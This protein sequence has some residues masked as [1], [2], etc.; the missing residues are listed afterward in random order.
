MDT[1]SILVY[2]DA[3]IAKLQTVRASIATISFIDTEIPV[4]R[5]PGR[6]RKGALVVA[7]PKKRQMSA[8]GRAR[9]A[10]AQKTR[11]AAKKAVAVPAKK[12]AKK[13]AGTK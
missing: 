11:W 6:P 9:I 7:K 8:A 1:S 13:S 5:G 4:R 10:A 3:Q 2:I 12:V